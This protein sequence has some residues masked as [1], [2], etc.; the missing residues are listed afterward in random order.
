MDELLNAL[1]IFGIFLILFLPIVIIVGCYCHKRSEEKAQLA[2]FRA[3]REKDW[4]E[5]QLKQLKIAEAQRHE[6]EMRKNQQL[7]EEKEEY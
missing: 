4:R 5:Y 1:Y 2:V 6:E 3:Q 7:E